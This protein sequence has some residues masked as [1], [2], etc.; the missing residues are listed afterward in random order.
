MRGSSLNLYFLAIFSYTMLNKMKSIFLSLSATTLVLMYFVSSF[1]K[2]LNFSKTVN[3]LCVRAPYIPYPM[4]VL[5]IIGAIV[6]EVVAPICVVYATVN[7]TDTTAKKLGLYSTYA[8]IVF[9][10]LATLLYHFPPN[11]SA[12]YYPFMSNVATT[13]GLMVLSYVFSQ[14]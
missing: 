7:T 6:I 2:A 9:T 13:G 3:G 5:M 4:C 1:S 11:N 14:H 8:L 12:R 10:I